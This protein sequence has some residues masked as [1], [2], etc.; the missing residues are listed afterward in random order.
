[1]GKKCYFWVGGSLCFS[2]NVYFK[3]VGICRGQGAAAATLVTSSSLD[4]IVFVF[5]E[6]TLNLLKH[7]KKFRR[8]QIIRS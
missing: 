1:M 6:G 2:E 5:I 4:P 3:E 7:L 8:F